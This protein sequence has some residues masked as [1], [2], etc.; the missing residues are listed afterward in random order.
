MRYKDEFHIASTAVLL[1]MADYSAFKLS[2]KILKSK[3][4]RFLSSPGKKTSRSL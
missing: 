3:K 2:T 1:S 4:R